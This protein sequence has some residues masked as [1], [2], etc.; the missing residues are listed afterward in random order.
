MSAVSSQTSMRPP[1]APSSSR[2]SHPDRTPSR[3]DYPSLAEYARAKARYAAGTPIAP[4]QMG[5]GGWCR[6]AF[7][8]R[9][10]GP[11]RPQLRVDGACPL[12]QDKWG[13]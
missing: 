3:A 6:M 11:Q 12:R 4:G 13:I 2:G 10:C 8:L 7:E 5:L 9:F 1:T